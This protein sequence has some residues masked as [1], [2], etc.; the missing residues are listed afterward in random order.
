MAISLTGSA[1]TQ[2]NAAIAI[3]QA[4][5]T[6]KHIIFIFSFIYSLPTL[7]VNIIFCVTL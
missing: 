2:L 1:I 7:R 4:V 5:I 3:A 6:I